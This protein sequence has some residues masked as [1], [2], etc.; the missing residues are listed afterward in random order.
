LLKEYAWYQASAN[1][2]AWPV[3][4]LKPNDAGLFDV[5][6]NAV[7]WCQDRGLFYRWSSPTRAG[8][9]NDDVLELR[10][11]QSR[12]LRGGSFL[13]PAPYVRSADRASLLPALPAD[14]V[15]FRVARTYP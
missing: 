12:V 6:G 4:L 13:N 8:E 2:A 9:E 15:G 10:D 11:N 3:G 5:Y 1:D 14:S 7:E